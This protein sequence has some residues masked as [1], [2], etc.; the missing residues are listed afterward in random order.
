MAVLEHARFLQ[1][2]EGA[3]QMEQY[4][5]NTACNALIAA[6][7]AS[8]HHTEYSL[9]ADFVALAAMAA[10]ALRSENLAGVWDDL[11]LLKSAVER[12]EISDDT[13]VGQSFFPAIR[14]T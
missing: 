12:G 5:V 13:P 3:P 2:L 11:N 8:W 1:L 10:I 7:M 4:M 9:V 14:S 6:W